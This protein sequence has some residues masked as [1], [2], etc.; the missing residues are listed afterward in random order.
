LYSWV[1]KNDVFV[2]AKEESARK[3]IID[4]HFSVD[5][6]DKKTHEKEIKASTL[7]HEI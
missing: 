1:C 3:K 7:Q 5:S 2:D 4:C 6:I